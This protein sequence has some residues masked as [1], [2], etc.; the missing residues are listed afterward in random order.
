[1]TD[2]T[3]TT[4]RGPERPRVRLEPASLAWLEALAEGDDVFTNRFGIPV[5]PGWVVFPESIPFALGMARNG[6][7]AAWGFHLI[8]D[9]ADGAL[10]G[11]GGWT[12][13]P[14]DGAAEFGYAIAESRRN[15]GLATAMVRVMIERGRAAGLRRMIA[16]TLPEESASTTVLS[17]CGFTRVSEDID[18]QEGPVWRWELQ[19]D[20]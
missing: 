13:E 18:P 15:R 2:P 16:H 5:V 8:L 17:R 12:G 3:A 20:E 14:V 7:P 11:N 4:D 6:Q 1:M 9:D 19:V 10:V